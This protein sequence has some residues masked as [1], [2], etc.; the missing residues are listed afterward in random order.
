MC[1]AI[2]DRHCL[3]ERRSAFVTHS[4]IRHNL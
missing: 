2:A 3:H 4:V 1:S